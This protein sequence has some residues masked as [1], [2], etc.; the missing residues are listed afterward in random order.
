MREFEITTAPELQKKLKNREKYYSS[1]ACQEIEHFL[2]ILKKHGQVSKTDFYD[3]N[4]HVIK[5]ITCK[6]FYRPNFSKKQVL[7]IDIKMEIANAFKQKF[8]IDDDWDD[9][10]VLENIPQYDKPKKLI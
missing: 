8:K 1:E 6:I 10:D 5:G 2:E 9:N 4:T 7:L 3:I